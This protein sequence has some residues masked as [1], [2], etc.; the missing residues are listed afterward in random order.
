MRLENW[1][2][3]SVLELVDMNEAWDLGPLLNQP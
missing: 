1:K 2:F 3:T